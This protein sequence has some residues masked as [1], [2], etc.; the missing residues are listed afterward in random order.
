M[1]NGCPMCNGVTLPGKC[2][3]CTVQ[4]KDLGPVTN[5]LGPYSPYEETDPASEGKDQDKPFEVSCVH[6]V[7]CP[8]C[9]YDHRVTVPYS[10]AFIE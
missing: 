10:Q 5:F 6:L 3:V 8:N 4:M 9:Q 1:F 7:Y 2:P